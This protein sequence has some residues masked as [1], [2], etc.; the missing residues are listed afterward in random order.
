MDQIDIFYEIHQCTPTLSPSESVGVLV[1]VLHGK[2]WIGYSDKSTNE[3]NRL[4]YRFSKSHARIPGVITDSTSAI[5]PMAI[6]RTPWTDDYIAEGCIYKNGAIIRFWGSE[7]DSDY[8]ERFLFVDKET[9]KFWNYP[10][11][12]FF[13]KE[14]ND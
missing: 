11:P 1:D 3:F 13:K 10:K 9:A 2:D 7:P 8:E 14:E 6:A 5:I 4:V 12:D